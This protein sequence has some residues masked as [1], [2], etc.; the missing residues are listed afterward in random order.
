M[1]LFDLEMTYRLS[2]LPLVQRALLPPVRLNR[3][4]TWAHGTWLP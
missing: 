3:G 2:V 4:P 1:S